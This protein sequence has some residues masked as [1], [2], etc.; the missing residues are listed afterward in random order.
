MKRKTTAL[1]L[2]L[3]SFITVLNAQIQ[4]QPGKYEFS[5]QQCIDYGIKNNVQV[6]NALLDY[7]I[8][9]QTNKNVTAAAYPQ[10]SASASTTY[11]PNVAVQT[12]PNFIA[13]ATYG[14]LEQ[15]GVKNGNGEP[16]K[17]P[18]DFG[19]IHAAFGTKWNGNAGV[20]LSQILFDGEV[21]VG[22]Q[23]RQTVLDYSQKNIEVTQESIKANIYKVY[24]QLVASKT[25][26]EQLDA[27][28][29]RTQKSLHDANEMF[30]NGFAEKIDVDRFSVQLANLQTQKMQ[31]ENTINNGYLGLKVLI[32]MPLQDTLVLT[33]KITE[34]R[35]KQGLLNEGQYNYTD[36]KDYQFLELG[37]KLNEYNVRR[38]KLSKL[39]TASISANYSKVAMRDQFNL[40]SKGDWFTS[41]Y[42]G[43]N[44][45]IPIFS[46][47]AQ[48]A[49]IEKAQ[50]ELKQT[51]NQI[52]NMKIVID[53]DVSQA[54]NNY[55]NAV[56]T[57]DNQQKNMNLAEQVYNQAKKKY[58]TG[59]GSNLEIT[60]AQTDLTIAQTNY[61]NALYQAIIAYVD[62]VK[63]VGKL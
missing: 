52:E 42:I 32:G 60:N 57:L 25:Q 12:F 10:I 9:E 41:S 19:F 20:S 5:V 29:A 8:Q 6:K 31:V 48:N 49:N 50:L 7:N 37:K 1:A 16:I 40:F 35:I 46:G 54:T 55:H 36:R 30:K 34:D 17:S 3:C 2:L 51:E 21:F 43:L 14:V 45:H 61:I 23:A 33:D 62:Y 39:P 27:N 59:T 56:A 63:A 4:Q 26:I 18:D 15:E 47:F 58:E 44:I 53:N 28:I 22:L 13:A 38:Y 11:Y 24:F